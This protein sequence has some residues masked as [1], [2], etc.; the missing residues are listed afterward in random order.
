MKLNLISLVFL[1]L[2]VH[3]VLQ[4]IFF[5]LTSCRSLA[6][7]LFSVLAPSVQ[8]QQRFGIPFL[9]LSVH[10]IHLTLSGAT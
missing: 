1:F 5:L 3:P 10:P 8:L 7:T 9:T 4:V 2:T 6:L